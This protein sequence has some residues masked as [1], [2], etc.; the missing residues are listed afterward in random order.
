MWVIKSRSIEIDWAYSCTDKFN[1]TK[2]RLSQ[3]SWSLYHQKSL[4][5][6]IVTNFVAAKTIV[7]C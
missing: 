6:V 2:K 4:S 7:A 5:L 1:V 3:L